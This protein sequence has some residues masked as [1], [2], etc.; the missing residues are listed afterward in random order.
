MCAAHACQ[1]ATATSRKKPLFDSTR[2]TPGTLLRRKS[3][4]PSM[5]H[6]VGKPSR[7]VVTMDQ[8]VP[9]YCPAHDKYS[10]SLS[11]TE[12][13]DATRKQATIGR[14]EVGAAATE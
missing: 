7:S 2:V 4:E 1:K 10:P 12:V 11:S 3:L 8:D 13:T 5:S 14:R 9:L 6:T